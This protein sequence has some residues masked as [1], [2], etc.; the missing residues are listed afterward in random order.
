MRVVTLTCSNTEIV[1]ALGCASMLVGV[2]E[3]S[4]YPEDV[5]EQLP[6]VGP[7]LGIDIDKVAALQPDL[8]L[9]SLTVPG[10]EKIVE[11]LH[12]AQLPFLAPEP[13]SLD[14][15]YQNIYE[16]AEA[17]GV[18]ER[19][20]PVVQTMKASMAPRSSGVLSVEQ[21]PSILVQWWPKPVIVPGRM[22]WTHDLIE[23]AGGR[24]ILGTEEIKSRPMTDEEVLER[25]PDIFILSWCGVPFEK[26]RP[27][28][29]LRNPKWT[30]LSAIQ[31]QHVY[32]IS[33][34]FMGRP[35]PRL[36]EGG[37]AIRAIVERWLADPSTPSTDMR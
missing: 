12:E 6:R 21:K 14:D 7:D 25:D 26:Y 19:A 5:V 33:E 20:G 28:I 18:P 8:V 17:L 1:C 9:A 37:K 2:D 23:W 32:C 24:N 3:H 29:L 15:I 11:G 27:D 22:S 16:I 13:I 30:T 31:N 34:A 4:D 10:H 36:A 35:S